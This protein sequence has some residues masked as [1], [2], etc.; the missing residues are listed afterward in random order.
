MADDRLRSQPRAVDEALEQL[1]TAIA[2]AI[3]AEQ[4]RDRLTGLAN[5]ESLSE[6][7]Q[8]K[9][10]SGISFWIA[11]VEVDRFKS[12][13]DKYGYDDA[14]LLLKKIAGQLQ[15]G[16]RDFFPDGAVPIRAHGDE[17]FLVGGLDSSTR[18]MHIA[19]ALDQIRKNIAAIRLQ[20]KGKGEPLSCT[21]SVGWL[22]ST[23]LLDAG[24]TPRMHDARP[25]GRP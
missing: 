5:D 2:D 7:I 22:L 20:C 3:R 17:F 13:N 19:E 8:D 18:E 14:D 6:W 21:V 9:I 15:I 24:L 10:E 25:G 12:I 23:D 16:A 4:L 1:R 11:F